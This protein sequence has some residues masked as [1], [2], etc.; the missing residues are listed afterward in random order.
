M[1]RIYI[2]LIVGIIFGA[3]SWAIVPLVSNKFEPFDSEAGFYIGQSVLSIIAIYLGYKH[4]LKHVLIYILGIYVSSN[5]YPYIFGSS[6]SRVWAGLGLITTLALC[7]YPLISGIVGK[8]IKIV[9]IK[10]NKSL[11]SGTLQSGA[12]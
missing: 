8:I 10:Y 3:L 6:E 5:A 12:P 4:S 9:Y 7:I 2:A 1:N 11:K